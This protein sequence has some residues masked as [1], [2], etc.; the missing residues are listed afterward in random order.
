MLR[1]SMELREHRER[2]KGARGAKG[3][4]F[5]KGV[6]R[7]KGGRGRTFLL[8]VSFVLPYS[9]VLRY[10]TFSLN[11]GAPLTLSIGSL[12]SIDSPGRTGTQA[13]KQHR[14]KP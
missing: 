11:S 5:N 1:E 4:T 10:K 14:S 6:L 9:L 3:E 12:N 13:Q 8:K 7:R 2:V